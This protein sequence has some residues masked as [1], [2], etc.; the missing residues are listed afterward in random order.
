MDQDQTD[1]QR[2]K[3]PERSSPPPEKRRWPDS[4][5]LTIALLFGIGS[6]VFFRHLYDGG[7]WIR[8]REGRVWLAQWQVVGLAALLLG[9]CVLCL[10]F[11]FKKK[12]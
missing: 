2:E 7:M 4:T 9:L 3:M 10:S 6:T 5:M 11:A 8:L 1:V 12:M